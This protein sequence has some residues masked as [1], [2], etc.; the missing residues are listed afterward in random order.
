MLENTGHGYSK[1]K[2]INY[3]RNEIPINK[4]ILSY[5]RGPH[6]DQSKSQLVQVCGAF[7]P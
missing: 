1:I 2:V 4:Y 5:P 7:L 6:A 3:E